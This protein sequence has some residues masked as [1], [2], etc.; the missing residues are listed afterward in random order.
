MKCNECKY[1]LPSLDGVKGQCH[2][3]PPTGDGWT[4]THVTTINA[5]WCGE[6][7]EKDTEKQENNNGKTQRNYKRKER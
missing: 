4:T 5:D 6:Y 1:W 7:E 3:Y 2:R